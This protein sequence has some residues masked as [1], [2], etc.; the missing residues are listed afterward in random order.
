MAAASDEFLVKF[1]YWFVVG[2]IIILK[3]CGIITNFKTWFGVRPI[4]EAA[5]FWPLLIPWIPALTH[6]AIKVA[7]YKDKA[8]VNAISSGGIPN[9]PSY[10]NDVVDICSK[11]G[12]SKFNETPPIKK[13]NNG[14]IINN[15]AE[16]EKTGNCFPWFSCN[17]FA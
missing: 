10:L 6:S 14:R 5:S 2:G 12:I 1:K 16:I 13:V 15:P 3:A 8:N 17:F 11:T 7:V 9:P 4:D